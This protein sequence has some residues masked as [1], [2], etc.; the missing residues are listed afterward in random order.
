M[1]LSY[2]VAHLGLILS[3]VVGTVALSAFAVFAKNWKA[4]V[5]ALVLVGAG[6]AFQEA[7]LGG[8]KRRVSEEAQEQVA[9]LNG[10]LATLS[11]VTKAYNERSVM[12][13]AK[14]TELEDQ[15]RAT[16]TN[17]GVCLDANSARRV[18]AI[19][20][21]VPLAAPVSP[22]RRPSVLPWRRG[23]AR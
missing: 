14:I 19:G 13:A 11:A 18:R 5:A 3:V 23:R 17:D 7:D 1:V 9:I 20:G 4:A 8:Y 22:K 15:A 21:P 10:R 12:D 16:P 2:I 6:L